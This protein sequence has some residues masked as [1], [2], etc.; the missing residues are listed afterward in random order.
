M[1]QNITAEPVVE[2]PESSVSDITVQ[3][4]VETPGP[5]TSDSLFVTAVEEVTTPPWGESYEK[6]PVD[7]TYCAATTTAEAI[8]DLTTKANTEVASET[9]TEMDE[10]AFIDNTLDHTSDEY[11]DSLF[12]TNSP[13]CPKF[14]TFDM[15]RAKPYD[16][17]S[18]ESNR[19]YAD[20]VENKS[21]EWRDIMRCFELSRRD[22]TGKG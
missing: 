8:T 11:L 4:A 6:L 3:P 7:I 9:T 14:P 10:N 12:E 20:E 2:T 21:A 22:Y 5:R 16:P 13:N 17:A 15:N 18:E 19:V 1:V